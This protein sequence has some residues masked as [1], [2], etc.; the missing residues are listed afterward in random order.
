MVF[1]ILQAGVLSA[2]A[3]DLPL[4][5]SR[6]LTLISGRNGGPSGRRQRSSNAGLRQNRYL[7]GFIKVSTACIS[8]V[9]G[10]RKQ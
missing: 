5:S 2:F 4:L 6:D 3:D 7:G 1:L 10:L 9:F 8:K